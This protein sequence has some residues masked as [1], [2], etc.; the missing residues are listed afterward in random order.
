MC[1]TDFFFH[2][3]KNHKGINKYHIPSPILIMVIQLD[4][5]I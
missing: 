5:N 2:S 1:P 4:E 3:F